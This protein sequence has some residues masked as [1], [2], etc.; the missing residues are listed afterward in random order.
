MK[1]YILEFKQF[2][3]LNVI[4]EA[5]DEFVALEKSYKLEYKDFNKH[6]TFL[7]FHSLKVVE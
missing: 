4:I 3:E 2:Q 6:C 5:E 7:E 1:Q